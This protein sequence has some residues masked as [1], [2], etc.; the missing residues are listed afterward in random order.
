MSNNIGSENKQSIRILIVDDDRV[1]SRVLTRFLEKSGFAVVPVLSANEGLQ[2]LAKQEIDL[3]LLDV[4]MPNM[5]GIE[6]LALIRSSFDL[7][8]II[9]SSQSDKAV[10]E[11]AFLGGA[12]DYII[13]PF[14]PQ[15]LIERI[16]RVMKITAPLLDSPKYISGDLTLTP[17]NHQFQ[18]GNKTGSLSEIETKLL[19]FFICNPDKMISIDELLLVGWSQ[20]GK[21]TPQDSEMLR[22]AI[23][24]LRQKIE[25]DL[26]NPSYLPL[27][28]GDGYIFHPND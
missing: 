3:T 24:H 13:K 15:Q 1:T 26:E 16:T 19:Q 6:M 20:S 5:D 10:I 9:L 18:A 7:P 8:V 23:N 12:D 11:R 25:P 22:L 27:V 17:E 28:S 2:I 21:N 4:V 14:T